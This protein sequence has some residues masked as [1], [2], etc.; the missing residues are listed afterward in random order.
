M[1]MTYK[2]PSLG[3]PLEG[4]WRHQAF[5]RPHWGS[6]TWK[7]L[8]GS[9]QAAQAARESVIQQKVCLPFRHLCWVHM[10][11]LPARHTRPAIIF[12]AAGVPRSSLCVHSWL[13]H[14]GF[15]QNLSTEDLSML[16]SMSLT[17]APHQL[18]LRPLHCCAA[19]KR[20]SR[21]ARTALYRHC[22]PHHTGQAEIASSCWTHMK[23]A[24]VKA[25][26]ASSR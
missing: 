8:A 23:L 3:M 19:A 11:R 17:A 24:S 21:L 12:L 9:F 2:V 7:S 18:T 14:H 25:R 16:L 1:C 13:A 20:P 6:H 22:S 15:I 26:P 4:C 5:V 10:E